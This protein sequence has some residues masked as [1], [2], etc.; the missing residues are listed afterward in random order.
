MQTYIDNRLN[1]SVMKTVRPNIPKVFVKNLLY[2]SGIVVGVII[3]LIYLNKMVGLETFMIP[4]EALGITVDTS[5]ILLITISAFLVCVI[6]YLTMS[7]LSATNLR[8]EFY[9]DRLKIYSP[10]LIFLVTPKEIQY[11]NVVKIS[12]NYEGVLN[13]LLKAG[14]INIDVTGMKE[15]SVKLEFVDNTEELTAQ[16]LK[17]I[18]DY[19]ALQQ[20]QFEENAKIGNIMKRF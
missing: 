2:V 6:I 4:F 12:Y 17:M 20:M 9:S 1:T 19:N 18:K 11:R 3:L 15:G 13:K 7:Y 8:Y 16:M 10:T 5:N 14:D